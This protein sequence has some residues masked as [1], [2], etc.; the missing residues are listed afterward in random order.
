MIETF[1]PRH[2]KKSNTLNPTKV[3]GTEQN[4]IEKQTYKKGN[5]QQSGYLQK[6][7]LVNL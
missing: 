3:A 4:E 2:Q 6:R 7:K 5:E 1:I